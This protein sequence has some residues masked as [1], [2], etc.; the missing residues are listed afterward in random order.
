MAP[1]IILF[2]LGLVISAIGLPADGGESSSP[3]PSKSETPAVQSAATDFISLLQHEKFDDAEKRFDATMRNALPVAQLQAAWRQTTRTNGD[4]QRAEKGSVQHVAQ[5]DVVDTP[6][7]FK[8]STVVIRISFD[9]QQQVSGLF[10]LP[11]T[12]PAC[13]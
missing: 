7:H 5:W 6:C 4:F 9:K 13:P 11:A 2:V 10:F 12:I 3:P 1:K 8:K